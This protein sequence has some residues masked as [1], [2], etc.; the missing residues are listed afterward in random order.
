ML[1]QRGG[2]RLS[3]ERLPLLSRSFLRC[4]YH[5]QRFHDSLFPPDTR[6]NVLWSNFLNTQFYMPLFQLHPLWIVVRVIIIFILHQHV[7]SPS[8][9]TFFE[10]PFVGEMISF[11]GRFL[12]CCFLFFFCTGKIRYFLE[13]WPEAWIPCLAR[14]KPV[15]WEDFLKGN[16]LNWWDIAH[17]IESARVPW[18]KNGW[19]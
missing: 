15:T 8:C 4:V 18:I 11:S 14:W 12:E 6:I 7:Y 16:P 10:I 1:Y 2:S 13:K 9:N 5:V 17:V 3:P 19:P